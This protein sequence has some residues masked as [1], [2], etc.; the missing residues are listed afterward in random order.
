MTVLNK[1]LSCYSTD[2]NPSPTPEKH[3]A[4][5]TVSVNSN[6]DASTTVP[7]VYL[8]HLSDYTETSHDDSDSDNRPENIFERM[9]QLASQRRYDGVHIRRGDKL[10]L[11]M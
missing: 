2:N 6:S 1:I 4:T 11:N 7:S 9:R 5:R 3:S 10:V 8:N